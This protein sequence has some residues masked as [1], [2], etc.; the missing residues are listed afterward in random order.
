VNQEEQSRLLRDLKA[1]RAA[2]DTAIAAIER[3]QVSDAPAP[4]PIRRGRK[5]MPPAERRQ[6][7]ERMKKYW[8]TRRAAG[9]EKGQFGKSHEPA[10]E[11]P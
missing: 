10:P 2:I 5:F 4:P 8:E 9:N 1:Q 6:V 3:L 7:S 11:Q